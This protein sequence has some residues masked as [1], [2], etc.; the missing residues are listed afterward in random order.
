[1]R[2]PQQRTNCHTLTTMTNKYLRQQG[3]PLQT[4][5]P[6][7][8]SKTKTIHN[9]ALTTLNISWQIKYHL[10]SPGVK[11]G[12][13]GIIL[14][15]AGETRAQMWCDATPP[16]PC[17]TRRNC[18]IRLRLSNFIWW[19]ISCL[20]ILKPSQRIIIVSLLTLLNSFGQ[21]SVMLGVQEPLLGSWPTVVYL[22]SSTSIISVFPC[23]YFSRPF[24][25]SGV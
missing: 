19:Q 16:I 5:P 20:N 18:V 21:D 17:H 14:L 9:N 10:C 8:D 4:C 25:L 22:P 3:E 13:Q 23:S 12:R 11:L 1:M 15:S 24:P 2:H 6:P 7:G